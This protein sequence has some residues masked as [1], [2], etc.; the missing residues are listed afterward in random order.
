MNLH[1]GQTDQLLEKCNSDPQ[2][3]LFKIQNAIVKP[4]EIQK[5]YINWFGG[6]IFPHNMPEIF[7]HRRGSNSTVG[8]VYIDQLVQVDKH[9][10]VDTNNCS[11]RHIDTSKT[12]NGTY[13][14]AGPFHPHFGHALTES[15][16]RLWAFDNNLHDGVVFAV[17]LRRN[18]K[19]HKYTPP[20][21]FI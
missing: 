20:K 11:D 3:R 4:I 17:S 5:Q 7:R 15:I 12:Y 18:S 21:W 16:H 8:V 10:N 13:I 2:N 1:L 19:P 6:V 9:K 14:Y